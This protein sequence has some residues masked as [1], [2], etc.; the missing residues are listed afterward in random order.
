MS[1]IIKGL[2]S[3]VWAPFEEESRRNAYDMRNEDS[4]NRKRSSSLTEQTH[5]KRKR[6]VSAHLG[7][8]SSQPAD[9]SL[10]TFHQ[11]LTETCID[12]MARYAFAD[13]SP[14]PT[15]FPSTN[16]LLSGG[17]S[18]T[19]IMDNKIITITTS[20]CTQKELRDGLCDKCW[21]ICRKQHGSSTED[22]LPTMTSKNHRF[23]KQNLS[24]SYMH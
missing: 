18:Q 22:K 21:L 9:K 6:S 23:V 19:W 4:S 2:E 10:M 16:F 8:T 20:G 24:L 11:E 13:C 3:N 5:T 1:Y 12:L 17:H 15:R 14:L 7:R